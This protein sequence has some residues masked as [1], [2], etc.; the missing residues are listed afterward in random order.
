MLEENFFFGGNR[1]PLFDLYLSPSLGLQAEGCHHCLCV[2][3]TN[4]KECVSS[5][6]EVQGGKVCIGSGK[7]GQQLRPGIFRQRKK[8]TETLLKHYYSH[9]NSLDETNISFLACL[10]QWGWGMVPQCTQHCVVL[11]QQFLS[12]PLNAPQHIETVTEAS[13]EGHIM[14]QGHGELEVSERQRGHKPE[15]WIVCNR[16][17]GCFSVGGRRKL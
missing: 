8:N 7:S 1:A 4:Y 16:E 9:D 12:G 5:T 17:L 6:Q 14:G 10:C 3:T 11:Q 13:G 15:A 2:I